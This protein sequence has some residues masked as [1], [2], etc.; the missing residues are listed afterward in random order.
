MSK[1][2]KNCFYKKLTFESILNAHIRASKGKKDKKELVLFEMDLETNLIKILDEIKNDNY[3]FGEYREFKV[4]EPKERIIKSLPYRDRIVH[5]WYIHEFIKPYFYTRFIKDSYAC[6][7]N[8][9]THAG[10]ITLQKYMRIMKRKYNNY[11]VLKCDIK[12]FFYNIDKSILINILSKTIKDK[13]LLSF[14]K[15]ILNDNEK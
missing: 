14:T 4:Y 1:T 5:Q 11:Y 3:K 10:V 12:K 8:R 6:I 7:E 15:I 2:I 9:G 13:K